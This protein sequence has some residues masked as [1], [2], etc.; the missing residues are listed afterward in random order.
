[1]KTTIRTVV[2]CM[3][4]IMFGSVGLVGCKDDAKQAGAGAGASQQMPPT[5]VDVQVIELGSLPMSNTFSGRITAF[6]VSEVRPQ[7][8]GIID[9]I[10][11]QEG[12]MV[13]AGQ[14]LYRINTDNYAS[15]V[16]AAEASLNQAQANVGTA[17]ATLISQQAVYEQ[18]QADL[19]RLKGLL[20]VEAISKQ[21]HDQAV[22][23]VKT[24]RAGL[25][26]ARAN[27]SSA[28]A[29]VRSAEAGLSARRLDLSRTIVRAPI[30]G[31]SGISAVTKGALVASG[32]AAPLVT[33]S[34]FD[35]VYVD[36][37]QS[38]SEVLKLRQALAT[39]SASQGSAEVQL[40]LE[41]GTAY[42]VRGRL[43]LSNAH[44]DEATGSVIVRAIFPNN[45]GIL[46]PG[47][48]VNARLNQTVATNSVLLPQT[49]I[50]RT[51]QGATQVYLVNKD[52]KIELREVKTAGTQDG[53]WLITEG[54]KT[55]DRV[56]V[57]GGAKVKPEQAVEVR[58]LP[59]TPNE[60]GGAM[61]PAPTKQALDKAG[62]NS[63]L[64]N[65]A[66][67]TQTIE[68][69]Q[70]QDSPSNQPSSSDV[71]ASTPTPSQNSDEQEALA[72]A[73]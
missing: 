42:P 15:S 5:T 61:P 7:V 66:K 34:R 67:T 53:K 70:A 4:V 50:I 57:M 26:Q 43:I 29:M 52:N 20:E 28:E 18:A 19:A 48:Y 40:V 21:A 1:M 55:G 59:N 23:Q 51:P 14:P 45:E 30:S 10:L 36:I 8:T 73:D 62:Q 2:L 46:L 25:E 64:A 71:Q 54:L 13:Q 44:V 60:Q 72:M 32:Q 68:P 39:G 22:T 27:I 3:A 16:A 12:S 11:F 49:A 65:S 24:A 33:I 69:K 6:E 9:E 38:S 31:K 37:S 63:V 56:V 41:D 58:V 47:M 35:P 17:R